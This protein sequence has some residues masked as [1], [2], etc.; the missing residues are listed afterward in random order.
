MSNAMDL[1]E[2]IEAT[3]RASENAPPPARRDLQSVQR[4]LADVSAAKAAAVK[5]EAEHEAAQQELQKQRG[6]WRPEYVES[7]RAEIAQA[8]RARADAL[9]KAVHDTLAEAQ[10]Q[11]EAHSRA[12]ELRRVSRDG[13]LIG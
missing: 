2:E 8:V 3:R 13:V 11:V 7:R 5:L 10:R 6:N 9:D 12:S 4:L 1:I